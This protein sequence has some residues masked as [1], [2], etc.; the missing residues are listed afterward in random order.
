MK[1]TVPHPNDI[2]DAL[3]DNAWAKWTKQQEKTAANQSKNQ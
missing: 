1:K 3:S 2:A